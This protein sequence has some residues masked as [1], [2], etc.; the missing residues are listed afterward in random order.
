[1][2]LFVF[3]AVLTSASLGLGSLPVSSTGR[4]DV[5]LFVVGILLIVL[6]VFVWRR[7]V[8]NLRK[9]AVLEMPFI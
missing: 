9:R 7:E 4:V 1:M 5:V 6:A 2:V 3:G 8:A